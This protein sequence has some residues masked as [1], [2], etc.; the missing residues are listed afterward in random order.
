M[1]FRNVNNSFTAALLAPS[2]VGWY[3]I[4]GMVHNTNSGGSPI[5]L[6]FWRNSTAVTLLDNMGSTNDDTTDFTRVTLGYRGD[7]TPSEYGNI[8]IASPLLFEGDPTDFMAWVLNG[9]GDLRDPLAYD[10][11][12][13]ANFTILHAW[14]AARVGTAAFSVTDVALEDTVGTPTTWTLVS[15]MQWSAINTPF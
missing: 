14:P 15:T 10:D 9:G 11:T 6:Y 3:L 5:D 1:T 2:T 8:P 7:S 12:S 13:D 4:V